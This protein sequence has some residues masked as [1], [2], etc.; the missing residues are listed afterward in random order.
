MGTE[1]EGEVFPR[2]KA[3]YSHQKE[4][5]VIQ[6]AKQLHVLYTCCLL[7]CCITT[8]IY[9]EVGSSILGY[10]LHFPP[11][12]VLFMHHRLHT[13]GQLVVHK[14]ECL[15]YHHQYRLGTRYRCKVLGPT[16]D[17]WNQK[18]WE[19]DQQS[20]VEQGLHG[21]PIFAQV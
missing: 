18:L 8:L 7:A 12:L 4:S 3:G 14:L 9:L 17:L 15:D 20:V 21:L 10:G 11:A 13:L 16:L 5:E 19:W 2:G 1:S 6:V